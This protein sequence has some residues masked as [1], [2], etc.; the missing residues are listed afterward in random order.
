MQ[1]KTSNIHVLASLFLEGNQLPHIQSSDSLIILLIF[2]A[3]FIM[4]FTYMLRFCLACDRPTTDL[5]FSRQYYIPLF[6]EIL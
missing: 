4:H 5:V 6:I 3:S 1:E 2:C